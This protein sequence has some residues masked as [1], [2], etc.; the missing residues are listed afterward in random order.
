[1]LNTEETQ[2][3]KERVKIRI[4]PSDYSFYEDEEKKKLKIKEDIG[5]I[6][7]KEK[8]TRILNRLDT[9][10][11]LDEI[12]QSENGNKNKTD[13]VFEGIS[14]F[15]LIIQILAVMFN[16]IANYE[17]ITIL[18]SLFEI[19]KQ[20][21]FSHF[22]KQNKTNFFE[23]LKNGSLRKIPEFE[24]DIWSSMIGAIILESLGL[25]ITS[26]IFFIINVICLFILFLFP[27]LNDID[28]S[29]FEL[30]ELIIIFLILFVSVGGG[31]LLIF[32]KFMSVI[33][34]YFEHTF[35]IRKDINESI[36]SFISVLIS[37]LS[38]LIKITLNYIIIKLFDNSQKR[39]FS[40]YII[41]IYI[42][43]FII[44]FFLQFIFDYFRKEESFN[45]KF[46]CCSNFFICKCCSNYKKKSK[47]KK[48]NSIKRKRWK[49][50]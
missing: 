18:D 13:D 5:K 8:I 38:M 45:L 3:L 49:K 33:M 46:D 28:Y 24:I 39:K 26:A 7:L 11:N 47:R 2:N 15:W 6:I 29:I 36:S 12:L 19:I 40:I 23:S 41:L 21:I 16:L 14:F 22:V 25:E 20:D 1:M 10:N 35:L 42:I 43:P 9:V 44:S 27:F 17:L 48:Y 34:K 31:S 30:I 32:Q 37:L 4:N 50:M